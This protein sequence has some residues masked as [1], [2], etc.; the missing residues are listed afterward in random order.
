MTD[1]NYK[2]ATY[3]NLRK[4]CRWL[5][6]YDHTKHNEGNIKITLAQYSTET[7][8]IQLAKKQIHKNLSITTRE[9][10]YQKEKRFLD[11]HLVLPR[12]T[13]TIYC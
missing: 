13:S 1:N 10:L 8:Q 2:P 7:V 6:L 12:W 3:K 11:E 4:S 5:I 9:E